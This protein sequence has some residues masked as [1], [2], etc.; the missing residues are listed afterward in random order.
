MS[1]IRAATIDDVADMAR[2][3]A[4]RRGTPSEALAWAERGVA[5]GAEQRP[6]YLLLVAELGGRV[7]AYGVAS[8]FE[9]PDDAPEETAPAGLYLTGLVV[10]TEHRRC[11]LGAALVAR[12]LD[13]I[14]GRGEQA[15]YFAD[16]DNAPT[17]ALHAGFGF[18]PLTQSFWFPGL[19]HPDVP[20]TLYR[21]PRAGW[22]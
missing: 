10:D 12:R 13:W 7:V 15:L 5:R 21:L 4:L 6:G 16:D 19:A 2:L 18:Q 3:R 8:R 14:F 9:P 20:M 17:I 1:R 22:T 11:G